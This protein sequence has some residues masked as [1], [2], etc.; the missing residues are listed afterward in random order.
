MFQQ[1]LKQNHFAWG[2]IT[3]GKDFN[4][5]TAV[6]SHRVLRGLLI[7]ALHLAVGRLS[8]MWVTCICSI[9]RNLLRISKSQG[10]TGLVKYCKVLSILT[11]QAA[12]GYRV[13]DT[14]SL[15][16]RVSRTSAGLPRIINKAHRASIRNGN[17]AVLRMYLTIFGLYRVVEI[18]GKVKIQT[19]TALC[20]YK[21]AD[22]MIHLKFVPNFFLLLARRTSNSFVAESPNVDVVREA[23]GYKDEKSSNPTLRSYR[24]EPITTAGPLSSG[25]T[26]KSFTD[27]LWLKVTDK[28]QARMEACSDGEGFV[29]G[30]WRG[31]RPPEIII[32]DRMN[33][34][35]ASKKNPLLASSVGTLWFTMSHWLDSAMMPYLKDWA[36]AFDLKWVKTLFKTAY[37]VPFGQIIP[38]GTSLTPSERTSGLGK[39]GFLEEPA[40]KVR[41]VAMVDPLTQTLLRPLH[42]WLFSLLKRIPEDGTFD[43]TAPLEL[44]VS[45]GYQDVHSY[46]LSAATDRLPLALQ[47]GLLSWILGEKIA[48]L[49]ACLLVNRDY[50]FHP[51]TA[52]KYGLGVTRVRYAAGQPM[53]A[54]SSWAMLALTHHFCVQLAAYRVYGN[55]GVW[56]SRYAVLG[57][58][59]V[60]ADKA[61][62]PV[63]R[64]LMTGELRVD[65]QETKSLIS[66]NGTFEFAKRTILRGSDATPIS[67]KGLMA[68][69]RNLP[70]MEGI[71]AKIPGVWDHRLASIARALGYGYK[72]TGRLQGALSRRDRLQGLVVFLT[73]PGGLLAR[74]FLSW[75]SQDAWNCVGCLPTE[76]SLQNLYREVGVWA[77]EKLLKS[78][79]NRKALFTRDSKSGG[80][81]PTTWFPTRTLFDVYQN[82]VLR[83]ISEDLMERISQLELLMIQW[84]ARTDIREVDFNEFI[85]ELEEILREADSLPRTPKVA[86]LAKINIPTGSSTLKVWRRLRKFVKTD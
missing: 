54:Y 37:T 83:P 77:G 71:L 26:A 42:N 80:W 56:F 1:M 14:T 62:A 35:W 76:D 49:W 36:V 57:D 51:R 68:G 74:D 73:R 39:L 13:N 33:K 66:N 31:L 50:S 67:L 17:A 65:I 29:I 64:S 59:V 47:E 8:P 55:T 60:I 21:Q 6:K 12:G 11:Q 79:E 32:R 10:L 85:K 19:I 63:Y 72:V 23:L 5:Q 46:D 24:I 84:R 78:L 4:W 44:L 28:I 7:R 86:R 15:G 81:L 16:C 27:P 61:V 70:A 20:L 75:V 9:S 18:P 2:L 53:G 69:L 41:V 25:S 52:E 45:K 38:W 48:R 43:Q 3:P 34:V 82:L 40:G 58:D 22:L 30:L